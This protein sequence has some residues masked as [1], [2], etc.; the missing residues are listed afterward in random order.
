MGK[1]RIELVADFGPRRGQTFSGLLVEPCYEDIMKAALNKMKL[2]KKDCLHLVV[3][4]KK[5]GNCM[6]LPGTDLAPLLQNGACVVLTPDRPLLHLPPPPRLPWP[7]SESDRG[8]EPSCLAMNNETNLGNLPV[9]ET[10]NGLGHLPKDGKASGQ[11]WPLL[12][13]DVLPLLRKAMAGSK[14]FLEKNLGAYLS[15]DYRAGG[16]AEVA[17]SFPDPQVLPSRSEA[18]LLAAIRR[19]CRGLLVCSSTG[20]VL[21]RRLPKFFNVDEVDEAQATKLPPGG[22]ATRKLDGSQVTPFLLDGTIRWA[23]KSALIPAVEAFVAARPSYRKAE[24]L[25]VA[26]YTPIFEWCEA[27]APVGVMSHRADHLV[28]IAVRDIET[29]EFWCMERLQ[30]LGCEVVDAVPF[31][32]VHALRIQTSGEVGSEGVVVSWPQLGR[33]VKLKTAWWLALAAAQRSSQGSGAYILSSA[34]QAMSLQDVPAP[35]LW[36]AALAGEDDAMAHAYGLLP[37]AMASRLRQ[38]VSD[39]EQGV[40]TLDKELQDWALSVQM[41]PGAAEADLA[42][43]PGGWP[44]AIL[45]VYQHRSPMAESELRKFLVRSAV[46]GRVHML[47]ILTGSCWGKLPAQNNG[48]Q[49]SLRAVA[50]CVDEPPSESADEDAPGAKVSVDPLCDSRSLHGHVVEGGVQWERSARVPSVL[51]HSLTAGANGADHEI[52]DLGESRLV[53]VMRGFPGSG[54][55][56]LAA[57]LHTR[58]HASVVSADDFF[59]GVEGLQSAHEQCRHLF[60]R[61]LSAAQ[62]VIV[63]DNTNIKRSEY[64]FYIRKAQAAGYEVAILELICHSTRVLEQLRQRSVHNVPGLAAGAMWGRWEHDDKAFRLMP[65]NRR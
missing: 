25:V 10:A 59:T 23:S 40:Q 6:L 57:L 48:Q 3:R 54:K 34:L 44:L 52:T 53:I 24:E 17:A 8:D 27:G 30:T 46:A 47:E 43:V 60:C 61:C 37:P 62:P 22:F 45:S 4:S 19:E 58:V 49:A 21:A 63:V 28:L 1:V 16:A 26:G 39:V 35:V 38:F 55:S 29:G 5:H 65:L 42:A 33:L 2:K 9:A 64:A 13:G 14:V 50:A 41:V 11:P 56:T 18:R 12:S 32:D 51:A 15:F 31:D 36:Q 20:K 7:G